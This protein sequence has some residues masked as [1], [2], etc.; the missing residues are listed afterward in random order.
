MMMDMMNCPMM[1]DKNGAQNCPMMNDHAGKMDMDQ[2]MEKLEKRMDMM[3]IITGQI[4][5][6][7]IE[8]EDD[9]KD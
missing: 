1:S 7:M 8:S 6:Q 2:R 4:I 5:E 3:Q 9:S